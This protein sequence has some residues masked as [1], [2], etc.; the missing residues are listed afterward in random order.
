MELIDIKATIRATKG[1]GPARALRRDGRIPAVLYGPGTEPVSLSVN[2]KELEQVISHGAGTQ[3]LLNLQ[4][5]GDK[6][7]S[8]TAMIKE[9]QTHPVSRHFLH[10]D[11]YEIAMD[12]KIKVKIPV[13]T[14]G[15]AKGVENGGMLQVIRREI[16]VLCL[17]IEIPE[18]IEIDIT[19]LDIGDSI[20][21]NEIPLGENVEIQEEVNFTI[22]TILSPKTAESAEEGEE[23]LEA[24]ETPAAEADGTEAG[25]E[26]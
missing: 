23:E 25:D 12:R 10:V 14:T 20:H 4:I 2:I 9:L 21:I 6:P 26:E 3:V 18:T 11:F 15:K 24:G 1:N 22:L 19:D 8:K 16:E 7:A 13:V 17:P 5:E